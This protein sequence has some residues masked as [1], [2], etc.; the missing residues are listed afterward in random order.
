MARI[1]LLDAGSLGLVTHPRPEANREAA[2]WLRDLL[3]ADTSV[4]VPEISDYEVRRELIRARRTKGVAR[5]D[6]LAANI[7]YLPI[8]TEAM[9]HAATFW[10]EARNRGQPTASDESIDADVILAAQ[11][12]SLSKEENTNEIVVVTTNVGH[13]SRFVPAAHWRDISTSG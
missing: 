13:L 4:M 2:L 9:R 7:G 6:R 1:V 10:A 11:A 3:T 8:N 5:L 12:K